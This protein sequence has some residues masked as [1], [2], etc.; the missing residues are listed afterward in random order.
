MNRTATLT[1]N[2]RPV[3]RLTPSPSFIML[4]DPQMPAAP[5]QHGLSSHQLH[6]QGPSHLSPGC[7]QPFCRLSS[8]LPNLP[9]LAYSL[10]QSEKSFVVCVCVHMCMF[11]VNFLV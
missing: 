8:L 2:P 3:R 7:T 1:G 4:S 5:R 6:H 11:Q 9:A 10:C